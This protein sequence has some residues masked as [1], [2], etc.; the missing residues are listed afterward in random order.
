MHVWGRGIWQLCTF[1]ISVESKTAL[2]NKSL[3]LKNRRMKKHTKDLYPENTEN[4]Y[5][6][7]TSNW[8]QKW[9][10]IWKDTSQK[11]IN[12]CLRS[13]SKMLNTISIW[14]TNLKRKLKLKKSSCCGTGVRN[15][16]SIHEDLGLI[17]GP[18]QWV[19]NPVSCSL[20]QRLGSDPMLLWLWCKQ[21]AT[22][23][24]WPLAWELP[25]AAGGTL[26]SKKQKQNNS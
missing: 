19:K 1:S 20:G 4:S 25:Y 7:I 18:A 8:T 9:A 5:N 24:I 15:P 26:K 6:S 11:K 21:T 14:E 22:A 3:F 23:P 2:K 17:P 13:S 12:K 10:K 16:I